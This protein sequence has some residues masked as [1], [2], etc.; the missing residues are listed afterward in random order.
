MTTPFVITTPPLP[1]N[2]RPILIIGAGGIVRDAHLPAYRRQG[3]PVVGIVNR[4]RE[5]AE[6]LA[7]DFA[8]PHVYT[9]LDQAIIEA[10]P[11]VV[12]DV[13]LPS[14]AQAEVIARL[15]EGAS[16]LLQKPMGETLA[17]ATAILNLCAERQL[18]AA[19][20]FQLRFA[21][22]VIAAR[23]LIEQGEIGDLIDL[24]IRVA[25]A[26]PWHLWPFLAGVPCA[27]VYYHS[28]HYLDLCRSFLGTPA[29]ISAKSV[30]HPAAGDVAGTRSTYL[31]DYGDQVRVV[32][33]ANHHV[34]AKPFQEAYIQWAGTTGV[35]RATLGLL[36]NYP[37]GVPDE[38]HLGRRR[39]Q[40]W[41][42]TQLDI[43]GSWFP[44]AF[45]GPMASVMRA[46][47]NPTLT[48]ATAVT[49][50]YQTMRL[51]DAACRAGAHGG[52]SLADEVAL[53][54]SEQA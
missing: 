16:V 14:P 36:L 4:G 1:D 11:N 53:T 3:W 51:A 41:E 28:V 44:E 29:S 5:R 38:F 20:N 9:S 10:P 37:H 26:T 24:E 33:T 50:A 45:I 52:T 22:A 32:I 49:D 21:P 34:E 18:N 6:H 43:P 17:Q 54:D 25:A 30:S 12:F 40:T 19:V 27:E 13:A 46:A 48:P 31:L 39:G 35:I 7:A 47:D 15:P 23:H 8:I 2:P 42:W